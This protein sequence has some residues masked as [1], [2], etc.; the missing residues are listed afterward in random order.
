MDLLE[1]EMLTTVF[2][3]AKL[4]TILKGYITVV[5]PGLGVNEHQI[6]L[7]CFRKLAI[8]IVIFPAVLT[9]ETTSRICLTALLTMRCT[10]NI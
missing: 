2:L 3:S 8:A 1:Q 5:V 4:S 6:I 7:S 10:I 9:V